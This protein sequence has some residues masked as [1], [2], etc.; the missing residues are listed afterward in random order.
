MEVI[1]TED[2]AGLGIIG[3]VVRVKPGY[4]R[5]FLLPRGIAVTADPRKLKAL[6]HHKRIIEAKMARERE[7]WEGKAGQL[8]GAALVTEARAGKEGRLFGSVTSSDIAALLAEKGYQVDRRQVLLPEPIKRV[9]SY[10]VEVRVGQDICATISVEVKA[11]IGAADADEDAFEE[12]PVA[13][14]EVAADEGESDE[15]EPA[16]PSPV[17]EG[18]PPDPDTPEK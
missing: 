5:N 3:D 13:A 2:V 1:L 17:T 15:G 8:S 12:A 18:D 9:G 7:S 10:E 16:Q 6:T 14:E 4:A 11:I